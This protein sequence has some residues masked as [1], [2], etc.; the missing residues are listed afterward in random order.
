[1][2]TILRFYTP[3][4][5]E[6]HEFCK[7]NFFELNLHTGEP[8]K[9]PT[10]LAFTL[11]SDAGVGYQTANVHRWHR[12]RRFIDEEHLKALALIKH[13]NAQLEFLK[14]CLKYTLPS[15]DLK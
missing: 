11:Y 15:A 7:Q 12:E 4:T 9:Y 2:A 8:T 13:P 1:M 10:H 14:T 5:H 3:Y 6:L